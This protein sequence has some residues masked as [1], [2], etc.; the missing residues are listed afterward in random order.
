MHPRHPSFSKGFSLLVTVAALFSSARSLAQEPCGEVMCDRGTTC[1]HYEGTD[2]GFCAPAPCDSDAD[3]SDYMVC[4]NRVEPD[5][6]ENPEPGCRDDESDEECA[7]RFDEF[8]SSCPT[9]EFQQCEFKWEQSCS[10]ATDCGSGFECLPYYHCECPNDQPSDFFRQSIDGCDCQERDEGYCELLEE[11][12]EDDS[13]CP[14]AWQCVA[15]NNGPCVVPE[16]GGEDDCVYEDQIN[17]CAYVMV[18]LPHSIGGFDA[19]SDSTTDS[20]ANADEDEEGAQTEGSDG[21][22][23]G[24][25]AASTGIEPEG[26]RAKPD[27]V[28]GDSMPSDSGGDCSVASLGPDVA[29]DSCKALLTLVLLFGLVRRRRRKK[30]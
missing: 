27:E 21:S 20:A 3:C 8:E 15:F 16:G 2:V 6:P 4:V 22:A 14:Q 9:R 24:S 17:R 11:E 19:A 1:E 29:T 26:A 13:D 28:Q 7:A 25:E 30:S 23:G 12:C 18:G 5:C 10:E